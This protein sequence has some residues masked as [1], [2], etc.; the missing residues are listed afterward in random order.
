MLTKLFSAVLLTVGAMAVDE[1]CIVLW[2]DRDYKGTTATLCY[3][4]K[5][6]TSYFK[7]EDYGIESVGSYKAGSKTQ[8]GFCHYYDDSHK[9][10]SCIESNGP[11]E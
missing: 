7:L 2:E 4:S 11:V 5:T 6:E 3:A 1:N 8:F 9:W 10:G